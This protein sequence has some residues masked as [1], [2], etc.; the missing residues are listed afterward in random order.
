MGRGDVGIVVARNVI[1]GIPLH[2]DG[3]DSYTG[4]Y[5]NDWELVMIM[6]YPGNTAYTCNKGSPGADIDAVELYRQGDLYGLAISVEAMEADN[7]G[8]DWPCDNIDNDMDDPDEMLGQADGTAGDGQFSGYFSLNGRTVYLLMSEILE[9][10]DEL[11]IYEMFNAE[12]PDE[13]IE[14]YQVYLG[15]FTNDGDMAFTDEAFSVWKTGTMVGTI[16]G[17]W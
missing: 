5:E 6:D 11:V 9:N 13:I 16:N 14:D 10:D 12:N 17:L 1:K 8:I 15:Y 4:P 2:H 7:W 3:G